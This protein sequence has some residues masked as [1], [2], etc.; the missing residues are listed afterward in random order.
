MPINL[1]Y[2]III[3]TYWCISRLGS[4]SYPYLIGFGSIGIDRLFANQKKCVLG[5]PQIDYLGHVISGLAVLANP[6][7]VKAMMRWPTRTNVHDV[8][9]FFGFVGYY[10][11]FLW[12]YK[13]SLKSL[14]ELL[15]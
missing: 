13:V 10:R 4:S 15:K 11:R 3:I 9:R 7:K 5:Q 8:R 12:G 1:F 6:S 2:F 14:T